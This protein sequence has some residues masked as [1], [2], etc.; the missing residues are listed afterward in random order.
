[1]ALQVFGEYTN[2]ILFYGAILL[3]VYLN[4]AK[5]EK[6]GSFMYLYKTKFGLNFM[7]KASKKFRK[8]IKFFGYLGIVIAYLCFFLIVYLLFQ[9]AYDIIIDKPGALGGSPV[10]P[11]LP[12]AGLGITFPLIIGWISLFI[13]MIVHEFAHG[14]MA[15]AHD[16][17]VK[18]SGIAFF[19]PILGAF[20][21]PDEAK[22]EKKG[23][24]IQHS[25]FA[26]GP[27]SNIA[28]WIVCLLLIIPIV[29]GIV[30]MTIAQ[31]VTVG[32][33]KNDTL[34]VFQS[35]MP[36]N[37]VIIGIDNYEISNISSLEIALN[38]IK[39]LQ[40]IS[41]KTKNNSYTITAI[42]HPDNSSKAYIGIWIYGEDRVLKNNTSVQ[43]IVYAVLQW[44]FELLKW[45]GFLSINIGLI[46]LF[47]IF[48]TDG[49]RMLKLNFEKLFKK[50]EQVIK[51]WTSVNMLCLLVILVLLLFPL[52]RSIVNFIFGFIISF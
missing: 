37:S 31:G 7:E 26:A 1:M 36:E 2:V 48:I 23:H 12:I 32:I 9:S 52:L 46:N 22:L 49:A 41:V 6:H 14:I 10:I 24:K 4:R 35:G 20:V 19:G 25:I 5:F 38:N 21:E 34:P 8:P 15:R 45:T 40:E 42:S 16:V 44:L 43:K 28:L 51:Y 3:F 17:K 39:P 27:V 47:P 30:N 29:T 18:S 33:I 13:I 50:K 11:G